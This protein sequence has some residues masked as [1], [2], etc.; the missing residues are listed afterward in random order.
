MIVRVRNLRVAVILIRDAVTIVILVLGVRRTVTIGIQLEVRLHLIGGLIRVGH[1]DRNIKLLSGVR[2]QLGAIREGNGDLT[3]VLVN[4]NDV[5]LRSLEVLRDRE[6]R[7]LRNINTLTVLV[8]KGRLRLGFLT[9]NNQLVLVL[10]LEEVCLLTDH[11]RRVCT[12]SSAVGVLNT[13]RKVYRVTR[14]EL[15]TVD[16]IRTRRNRNHAGLSVDISGPTFRQRILVQNVLC[17]CKTL[18]R[19]INRLTRQRI[20]ELRLT[21]RHLSADL[22]KRRIILRRNLSSRLHQCSKRV[23][24]ESNSVTIGIDAIQRRRVRRHLVKILRNR[25][26]TVRQRTIGLRRHT[27]RVLIFNQ[28]AL[29]INSLA[30]VNHIAVT[31]RP[32]NLVKST[33]VKARK[34]FGKRVSLI[35]RTSK[36]RQGVILIHRKVDLV[37]HQRHIP[38]TNI[39]VRAQARLLHTAHIVRRASNATNIS[40]PP[41]VRCQTL[42]NIAT[43]CTHIGHTGRQIRCINK[44][45]IP[46]HVLRICTA[47]DLII[48]KDAIGKAI[49]NRTGKLRRNIARL[50]R[51]NTVRAL[52]LNQVVAIA[53]SFRDDALSDPIRILRDLLVNPSLQL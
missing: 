25:D 30:G 29:S 31:I 22:S 27:Q 41:G 12:I 47:G 46:V 9:R 38:R 35:T 5:A 8:S 24:R 37:R 20:N 4:L 52:E 42:P 51:V 33:Q 53:V 7:V 3:G 43:P 49:S 13:N 17:I 40:D 39:V 11:D 15:F 2:A 26:L 32:L 6:L 45:P 23:R 36:V 1:R 50:I 18:I 21:S 34:T 10:R 48:C 28:V 19:R 16:T 44:Q 14:L